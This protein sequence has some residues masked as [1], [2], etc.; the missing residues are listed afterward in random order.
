VSEVRQL[1]GDL[2]VA[3]VELV[4]G[5]RTGADR[6]IAERWK[7]LALEA[8]LAA[9]AQRDPEM[10]ATL[11]EAFAGT[12]AL[13]ELVASL[14]DHF[15]HRAIGWDGACVA[16][17]ALELVRDLFDGDPL[18]EQLDTSPLETRM[19]RWGGA[20]ERVISV[21]AGMPSFHWWW[22]GARPPGERTLRAN[23]RM[24]DLLGLGVLAVPVRWRQFVNKGFSE[25][26]GA[27]VFRDFA[28]KLEGFEMPVRW[29]RGEHRREP[30]HPGSSRIEATINV[31]SI[32][33][34]LERDPS[35]RP[36]DIAGIGLACA[37]HLASEL[38]RRE[39]PACRIIVVVRPRE[40]V[41]YVRFHVRRDD[42]FD[43]EAVRDLDRI[44]DEAVLVLDTVDAV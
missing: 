6:D 16:R 30:Y 39:L 20:G 43:D 23:R 8:G 32:E 5:L 29:R 18:G 9:R 40:R 3:S 38:R 44:T 36:V 41:A 13:R 24:F 10:I 11:A 28:R 42:Q 17:S 35:R 7:W 25:I 19:L 12:S 21:P 15:L 2:A 26:D 4:E 22:F 1:L 34:F 27:I 33:D 31:C 14:D 37:R